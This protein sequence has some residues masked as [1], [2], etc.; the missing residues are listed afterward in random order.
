MGEQDDIEPTSIPTVPRGPSERDTAVKPVGSEIAALAQRPI[1]DAESSAL[2]LPPSDAP[3]S[4]PIRV[5]RGREPR[6]RPSSPGSSPRYVA[7]SVL[8]EGGMGIVR[9]GHDPVIGRDIAIKTILKDRDARPDLRTRFLREA[10]VQGRLEH[11]S[12]V[13][14]YDM[15]TDEDGATYFTMRRVHGVTLASVLE[16]LGAGDPAATE[17]H[18]RHRLLS[19]FSSVCLAI[20]FAHER[21]VIHRDLKPG[22][23]MIGDYGEVYVL[24]W[25]VAKVE[26]ASDWHAPSEDSDSQATRAGSHVGTLGYMSPEQLTGSEI[27][28]RSDVYALGALLFEILTYLPLHAGSAPEITGSTLVGA[29]ARP[30][31]RAPNRAVAPELEALCVRATA[32]KPQDRFPTAR[33][34]VDALQ[35]YLDGDRELERRRALA[36]S[37]AEEAKTRAAVALSDEDPTNES[38]ALAMRDVGNALALD[39]ENRSALRTMTR[40]M[41]HPPRQTPP[42]AR[43]AMDQSRLELMRVT[44]RMGALVFATWFMWLP[45]IVWMGIR[46]YTSVIVTSLAFAVALVLCLLDARADHVPADRRSAT[47]VLFA[48][49][50]F[51]SLTRLFGPLVLLPTAL[52]GFSI[53]YVQNHF[54]PALS[55]A[56][57]VGG[58][59]LIVVPTAL[60]ALGALPASYT[61]EGGEMRIVSG[62]TAF[63]RVPTL[64]FLVVSN[65]VIIASIWRLTRRLQRALADAETRVLIQAWHLRLMVPEEA[66]HAVRAP[67]VTEGH[68]TLEHLPASLPKSEVAEKHEP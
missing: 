58:I 15:G 10:R 36:T 60:E 46:G 47:I 55:L 6:D 21:G 61:F 68:V 43:H 5:P 39:P 33:A 32:T 1:S 40:L 30:S 59:G 24:D 38:R 44:A 31:V 62:M 67:T 42:D 63:P 17:K 3:D 2:T 23:V 8:G 29:D 22:N 28:R 27:D 50:G 13:P 57:F 11:P 34:L 48:C 26:H 20:D 45:L 4:A 25:G 9:L 35:K 41:V 56:A 51:A 12:I 66:R 64:V 14:V 7:R 54:R 65:V 49:V 16:K 19:A 18:S 52:F 53:V 37:Y